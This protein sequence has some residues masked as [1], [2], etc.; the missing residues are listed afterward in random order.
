MS[1]TDSSEQPPG[2][3]PQDEALRKLLEQT[4]FAPG[5]VS[6][7]LESAL[8]EGFWLK[9]CPDLSLGKSSPNSALEVE[10][11]NA[12]G[13]D[14][15]VRKFEHEGYF[16]TAPLFSQTTVGRMAQCVEALRRADWPPVFAFV[17]DEFWE[18]TRG[19]ALSGLL[20]AT[21]GEG[22]RQ[23]PHIWS[24]YVHQL[25][26][27]GWRPHVDGYRKVK[28]A[29]V[30]IA[31][32]DA[33]LSNGCI[34]LIPRNM[35][36]GEVAREFPR[37]ES[38]GIE[39]VGALLH[40]SRALPARAGAVLGWGHDVIHWGA[41]CGPAEAPRISISQEFVSGGEQRAV[42]KTPLLDARRLPTFAA[43]LHV[44]ATAVV[45]Y[46]KFE[47]LNVRYLELAERLLERTAVSW[48][49]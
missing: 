21:L 6:A 45:A 35:A 7:R 9:L 32:S 46:Q 38:L 5:E 48:F 13:R 24:H 2:R 49:F 43:R 3:R 16:Q 41:S 12:P 36:P 14:A 22:Y 10:A 29:T 11:L 40:G 20:S 44:I 19:A 1:Q 31:L 33:T 8:S 4:R 18:V 37:L 34:Y 26:G 25:R 30:W 27:A 17:Y 47:P 39:D 15:L 42:D 28:R 23:L